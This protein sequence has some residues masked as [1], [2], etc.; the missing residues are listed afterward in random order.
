VKVCSVDGCGRKHRARGWCQMHY[1]RW[2]RRGDP[3]A[4]PEKIDLIGQT[5]HRLTVKAR[6]E[7]TTGGRST[8][9]CVCDHGGVGEPTEVCIRSKHLLNGT[10]RSCGCLRKEMI[11]RVAQA[12]KKHGLSVVRPGTPEY[13]TYIAYRNARNRCRDPKNPSYAHYGEIGIKFLFGSI[14]ELVAAIGFCPTGRS[15]DRINPWGDYEPSNVRWATPVEQNNNKRGHLM[16][17]AF[18]RVQTR[19][20]WAREFGINNAT[21]GDRPQNGWPTELALTTPPG[22]LGR[23]EAIKRARAHGTQNAPT[24]LLR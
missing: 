3:L 14:E 18:G 7:K 9:I 20:A 19:G 12:N 8:W 11:R 15:L 10:A 16:I 13:R 22:S 17:E 4:L 1:E 5:F 24:G 6:G 21:L 23:G 2:K